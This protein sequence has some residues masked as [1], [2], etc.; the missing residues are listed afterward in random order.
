MALRSLLSLCRCFRGT[1]LLDL[2]GAFVL[3]MEMEL[4][5][6]FS[7]WQPNHMVQSSQHFGNIR[8]L[9]IDGV[10]LRKSVWFV[11]TDIAVSSR[12]YCRILLPWKLQDIGGQYVSW[13]CCYSPSR[14]HSVIITMWLSPAL[15]LKCHA[16]LKCFPCPH[17]T[18]MSVYASYWQVLS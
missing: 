11:S 14:L 6:I 5:N 9:T 16:C 8:T 13:K 4:Q 3:K 12:R 18:R 10:S 15:S 1:Q 17:F 7:G 2:Q